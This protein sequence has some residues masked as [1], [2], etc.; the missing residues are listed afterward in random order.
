[1]S[2]FI[3]PLTIDSR[4]IIFLDLKQRKSNYLTEKLVDEDEYIVAIPE[5]GDG[6]FI[7][8]SLDNFLQS[9][10]LENDDFLLSDLKY[11]ISIDKNEN[12]ITVDFG[13]DSQEKNATEDEFDFNIYYEI[14]S[15]KLNLYFQKAESY[16]IDN[17]YLL[18]RFT[19]QKAKEQIKFESLLRFF[20][21]KQEKIKFV[22]LDF[23]SE[24]S[25]M[26]EGSFHNINNAEISNDFLAI[27]NN[28]KSFNMVEKTNNTDF[29]QF[30]N[31]NTLFKS[32]FYLKRE[33]DIGLLRTEIEKLDFEMPKSQVKTLT[34]KRERDQAFFQSWHQLPN[35]KLIHN[36][37]GLATKFEIN[38]KSPNGNQTSN[39]NKLKTSVY[40]VLL[41]EFTQSYLQTLG[42]DDIYLRFTILVPN[43]YTIEEIIETKRVIR[44]I[45][46][47]TTLLANSEIK[48]IEINNLSESD[49][50]FLGVLNQNAIEAKKNEYYITIDAGKGTTDLSIMKK[51]D[52][53]N[54]IFQS[55]YRT[56]FAGAGNLI[57][58][59][60]L[61]SFLFFLRKYYIQKNPEEVEKR[62]VVFFKSKF[63]NNQHKFNERLY[64][65]VEKW[66]KNYNKHEEETEINSHWDSLTD[67][68]VKLGTLFTEEN[69]DPDLFLG[70]MGVTEK[71]YDW[72]GYIAKTVQD[73]TEK[74]CENL[75]FIVKHLN[76]NGSRCG[77]VLLTG[78]AFMFE[79]LA[80][81][82]KNKIQS[83][84]SLKGVQFIDTKSQNINLKRVCLEGIFNKGIITY[85][86]VAS[87]PIE[88]EI[89][90][91]IVG[92]TSFI[93]KILFWLLKNDTPYYST[94]NKYKIK[95]PDFNKTIFYISGSLYSANNLRAGVFKEA[96]L[97]HSRDGF[98]VVAKSRN[99][100]KI[101]DKL[102][103]SSSNLNEEMVIKSLLPAT[104]D[105]K[106][107]KALDVI[108]KKTN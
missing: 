33:I 30:E 37:Q 11:S 38:V 97:I 57:S 5:H 79:P 20:V 108:I 89:N 87:T 35:L 96:Y 49:A 107:L 82:L 48:A 40:K 7:S 60:F 99:G 1:M 81:N 80:E 22:G 93:N 100:R 73:I 59:S 13:K 88:R 92:Q 43:I 69:Q 71:I 56:G 61:Q 39:L 83:L 53:G 17:F 75:E 66:K 85:S 94:S 10:N 62:V 36:A 28:V 102:S 58:F 42:G 41:K 6:N 16:P 25:Q 18:F 70:L 64:E 77:G 91:N 103:K 14:D 105:I 3:L 47:E 50:S 74:I 15:N 67:G 24:A 104:I 55:I 106:L 63:E 27:F 86:D 90:S 46:K 98:Y 29:D 21:V 65:F 76:K 26:N 68:G 32:K 51:S 101:I 4:K 9:L 2:S 8:I 23:G 34:T 44:K 52:T 72:N 45:I 31:D 19:P 12:I 84:N 54:N 78:R 95:E